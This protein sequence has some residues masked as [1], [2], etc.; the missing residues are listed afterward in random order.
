VMHELTVNKTIT[1]GDAWT[2][3]K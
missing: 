2:N 1:C 3:C